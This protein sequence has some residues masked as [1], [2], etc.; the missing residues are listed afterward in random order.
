VR[1][2]TV[3]WNGVLLLRVLM[4]IYKLFLKLQLFIVWWGCFSIRTIAHKLC[5]LLSYTGDSVPTRGKPRR[6]SSGLI[7][8]PRVG[9]AFLTLAPGQSLGK[10]ADYTSQLVCVLLTNWLPNFLEQNLSWEAYSHSASQEIPRILRNPKVYY[11]IHE[12][13]PL[14]SIL[15]QM[16][17]VHSHPNY[18][19]K[20]I[21][22]II[23]A[24][25]DGLLPSGFSNQVL[26]T[27][28]FRMRT[29]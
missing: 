22:N 4:K 23:L 28:I 26:C 20:I 12:S 10:V 29:T 1:L 3:T 14:V 15:S 27:F 11:C 21:S 2:V 5:R 17:P 16:N 18:F 25:P 6:A 8:M 19:P 9:R 24:L 13:P 7:S